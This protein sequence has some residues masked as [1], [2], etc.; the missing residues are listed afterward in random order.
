MEALGHLNGDAA[1]LHVAYPCRLEDV[2]LKA[3]D[4]LAD[5][6]YGTPV[7]YSDHTNGITVPIAAV[8]KGAVMIEKHFTLDRDQ[9]GPDHKSSITPREIK[10]MMLHIALIE[11]E[12]CLGDGKKRVLDCEYK[13]HEAWSGN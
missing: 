11:V 1:A 8:A 9:I 4:D 3:M 10:G 5:E 6:Y 12:A 2:N 13:L 7:G